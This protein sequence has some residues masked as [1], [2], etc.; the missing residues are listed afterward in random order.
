MPSFR[1]TSWPVHLAVLAIILNN[2][3][4]G[5]SGLNF[6]DPILSLGLIFL[7]F[8]FPGLSS[9][10][11][12]IFLTIQIIVGTNALL[13]AFLFPS[14]I[15]N[16][17]FVSLLK[18]GIYTL[19]V[20]LL[21]NYIASKDLI[22]ESLQILAFW[23][24]VT[25]LIGLYI[26]FVIQSR[27]SLP[28]EFFWE[29]T[30]QDEGSY[31]AGGTSGIIRTR[32]V[33][34]EP[35][36]LGFFLNT[37]LLFAFFNTRGYR[38]GKIA[39]FAITLT[40]I[41]TYSLST[42]PMTIAIL[43]LYMVKRYKISGLMVAASLVIVF[44]GVSGTALLSENFRVTILDRF[45]RVVSGDDTSANVRIYGSWEYFNPD[46]I[47]IGNGIGSTPSI[48]NNYAYVLT[49]LGIIPFILL[50]FLSFIVIKRNIYFG[51]YFVFLTFTKGGY[52]SAYFWILLA[53]FFVYSVTTKIEDQN[54]RKI[55]PTPTTKKEII[56]K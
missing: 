28:Y 7:F 45:N 15:I 23:A 46:A 42:I 22:K 5:T 52:L 35:Q 48:W 12:L 18:V 16:Q 44:F 53:L 30:R 4:M 1:F 29:Y 33:F 49:D 6:S 36:H 34:S 17:G 11:F 21:F 19:F 25:C 27:V 37:V 47:L 41:T 43:V 39:T 24:V 38:I 8:S 26:T 10:Q 54:N 3:T 40:A 14:Y 2:W 32:S 13:S 51:L 9:N 20:L 55:M 31:T 50:I 56:T